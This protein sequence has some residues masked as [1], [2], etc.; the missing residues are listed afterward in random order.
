MMQLAFKCGIF[1][2]RV[3]SEPLT[4]AQKAS[5]ASSRAHGKDLQTLQ[6]LPRGA[7]VTV[8]EA[9]GLSCWRIHRSLEPWYQN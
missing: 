5:T 3:Y 9:V 1:C 6:V 7:Q 4:L 2:F 8:E